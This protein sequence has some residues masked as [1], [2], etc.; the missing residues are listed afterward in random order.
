MKYTTTSTLSEML[1]K[2]DP[3]KHRQTSHIDGLVGVEKE[4]LPE[5]LPIKKTLKGKRVILKRILTTPKALAKG[6][7]WH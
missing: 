1:D 2:F 4:W 5:T 6:L 3:V 7:I